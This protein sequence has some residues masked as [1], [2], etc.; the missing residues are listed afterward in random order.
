MTITQWPGEC[1]LISL[2]TL[3]MLPFLPKS[4]RKGMVIHL[5]GLMLAFHH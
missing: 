1:I 3:S 5:V 4:L 2:K